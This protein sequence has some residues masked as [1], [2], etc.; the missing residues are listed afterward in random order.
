MVASFP[1]NS[2]LHPKVTE[3]ECSMEVEVRGPDQM[4]RAHIL[5]LAFIQPHAVLGFMQFYPICKHFRL[6]S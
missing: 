5:L 2:I 4:S 1:L 6:V 3:A